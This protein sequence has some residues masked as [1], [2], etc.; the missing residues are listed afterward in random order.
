LSPGASAY[1]GT[2]KQISGANA[3][4]FTNAIVFNVLSEDQSIIKQWTVVVKTATGIGSY[5]KKDAVCYEGGSIKVLFP[6]EKEEVVLST[7][8]ITLATQTVN[9]GQVIFT[10]LAEGTY[11]VSVGGS[12][13]EIKINLK[14]SL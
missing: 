5:Y 9:N 1:I 11:R 3:L 10:N 8:G 6:V 2:V 13:K 14:N 12:F 4:N 7:G